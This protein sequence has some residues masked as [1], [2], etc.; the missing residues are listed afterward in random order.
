ME[1]LVIKSILEQFSG[2]KVFV[3]GHT[4]FKGSWLLLWL[5]QMGAVVQGYSLSPYY[6]PSH[7][8]LLNIL[9]RDS[10][11]DILDRAKDIV[12]IHITIFIV[13]TI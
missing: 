10:I 2:K 6:S 1:N 4:G 5:Q 8:S 7:I 9:D 13:E 12:N 3:T 11:G